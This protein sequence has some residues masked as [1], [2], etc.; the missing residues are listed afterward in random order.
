MM[1]L[2]SLMIKI[3]KIKKNNLNPLYLP[4]ILEIVQKLNLKKNKLRRKLIRML[5]RILEPNKLVKMITIM[6][7]KN[8]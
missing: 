2:I 7:F 1:I 4:L 5:I 8:K 6:N 3:R